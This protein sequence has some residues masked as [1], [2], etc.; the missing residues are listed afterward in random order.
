MKKLLTKQSRVIAFG[1]L[2]CIIAALFYLYEY[3]LRIEPSVMVPHLL[4]HYKI[5]APELGVMVAMYY[6]AYTPLQTI[7]GALTDY[8]GARRVLTS[9]LI[10]CVLGSFVFTIAGN[11][12]WAGLGRFLM[13]MGSAFAFVGT[14]KMAT[15][16]LPRK[17]FAM[18]AGFTMT[19][20]MTGAMLGD[21]ELSWLLRE[22]GMHRV[23]MA[24]TL[25]GVVLIPIF[26]IF[27]RD[28][29]VTQ[30]PV[31]L[32]KMTIRHS[33]IELFKCFK[34]PRILYVGVI[35]C[36]LFLSLSVIA[37]MWGIPFIHAL[38]HKS[39][40]YDSE[41]NSMVFLGFLVG[42]PLSGWLSDWVQSRRLPMIIGAVLAALSIAFV[43][44]IPNLHTVQ[45]ALFLFLFGL[46]S[47]TQILCFAVAR[48]VS[49]VT[50]AG[51]ALGVVNFLVMLGAL[52]IQP[53]VGV[54]LGL[55]QKAKI[56]HHVPIYSLA[57]YHHALFI[58]PI[59]MFVAA[60]L[61]FLMKESYHLSEG[62]LYD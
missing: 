39:N 37:S 27:I 28:R 58:V 50:Y 7:V 20:A 52:I 60:F 16:W 19:V 46:G 45:L 18:F 8:F 10:L 42:S 14:L 44:Y 49:E 47:S 2:V 54:L 62:S 12:Y 51:T 15:M 21:I 57:A 30:T 1:W 48:D 35:G 59:G 3:L 22:I 6:F 24:V 13:G 25:A 4:Y 32:P 61:T 31:I 43:L 34:K 36:L 53:L 9:A 38:T 55:Y 41:I 56:I 40:V 23:L 26:F 17:H 29:D 5:G 33:L 11:I